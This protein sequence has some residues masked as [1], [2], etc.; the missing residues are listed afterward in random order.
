MVETLMRNMILVIVLIVAV[1]TGAYFASL[2]LGVSSHPDAAQI[3]YPVVI[4]GD[5]LG[6][7]VGASSAE[8]TFAYR[9]FEKVK[10]KYPNATLHNF[11]L[12][13]STAQGV[14]ANQLPQVSPVN[15][16]LIV[17]VVGTNDILLGISDEEF[18]STYGQLLQQAAKTQA[19]IIVLT[20]P[21]FV[22]TDIFPESQ[23]DEADKRA[24]RLNQIIQSR[25]NT[26]PRTRVFDFYKFSEQELVEKSDLL[27]NDGFHPNDAGHERIAA[28]LAEFIGL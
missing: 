22:A 10:T 26:T 28:E 9:L 21:K 17:I 14:V 25:A 13:G 11:A 6:V 1:L 7:G 5:S 3:D 4:L 8:N 2:K 18:G 23:Y 20:I 12:S 16:K 15:P 24:Q 19:D 27:A